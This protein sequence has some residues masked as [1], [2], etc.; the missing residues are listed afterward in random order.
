MLGALDHAD[1]P[2]EQMVEMAAQQ[3]NEIQS[4]LYQVMFVLVEEGLPKWELGQAETQPLPVDTGTSKNELI[5]SITAEGPVWDCQFEYATD[6]FAAESV[7]RMTA[8]FTELLHSITA[9]PEELIG[10]LNLLGTEEPSNPGRM[11]WTER[12]YPH[13]SISCSRS[14]SSARRR[15]GGRVRGPH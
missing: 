10:R 2:F 7:A 6:L 12:D 9:H 11:N 5:L 3:R 8:H 15:G 4:P 14:K 13:K 1:L